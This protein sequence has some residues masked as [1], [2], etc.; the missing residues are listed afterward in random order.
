MGTSQ[1]VSSPEHFIYLED[2][3]SK[4]GRNETTGSGEANDLNKNDAAGLDGNG[5]GLDIG[6]ASGKAMEYNMDVDSG[7]IMLQSL[8]LLIELGMK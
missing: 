1:V 5:T 6:V 2:D 3:A 7:G 8:L 4:Q